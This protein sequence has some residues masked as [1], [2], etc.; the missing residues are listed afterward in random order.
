MDRLEKELE[1]EHKEEPTTEDYH[2][3]QQQMTAGATA[4][5]EEKENGDRKENMRYT[6]SIFQWL[7]T[8]G[9]KWSEVQ[10]FVKKYHPKKLQQAVS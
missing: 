1:E 4:S 8:F 6:L 3:E 5:E 2:L 10:S 9:S 7:T